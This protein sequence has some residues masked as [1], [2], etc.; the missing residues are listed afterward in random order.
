[1]KNLRLASE[2]PH[3]IAGEG[4]KLEAGQGRGQRHH[5]S[6]RKQKQNRKPAKKILRGYKQFLLSSS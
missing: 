1:M 2:L 3:P 6:F 4:Y 5:R